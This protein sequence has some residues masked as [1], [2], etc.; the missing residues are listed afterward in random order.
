VKGIFSGEIALMINIIICKINYLVKI[1]NWIT[2]VS[3]SMLKQIKTIVDRFKEGKA[4][5]HKILVN[6]L[7]KI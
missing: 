5:T 4:S 6:I 2:V 3:V 7:F 1:A